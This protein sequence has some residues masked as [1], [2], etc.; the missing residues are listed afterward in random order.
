MTTDNSDPTPDSST[1][2]ARAGWSPEFTTRT[3]SPPVYLTTAFDIES[4]EQ[5]DA[6]TSGQEKGYIYTRDGNPNHEAFANDV[7]R[8]EGAEA[9]VVTASGMGALTAVLMAMT[10][11]GEQVIA[12]RV[13][14]GRTGQL[15]NHLAS[16][17]GLKVSYFDIDNLDELRT[18]VTPQT[19]LCIVESISN[20]LLEVADIPAIVE[21]LNGVPLL[22]DSTFATPCLLRPID[23]GAMLV[24]HSASK[25]LNGHGDVMA[26]VVVGPKSLIRKIRAMSSLYGVNANPFESWLAARGLRT[27][28]LR[29]SRVSQSAM[30]I[31]QFLGTKPQIV[32]VCYPG[33]DSHPHFVRAQKFLPNGCG[34][35]LAFDLA[36]GRG[37]VDILFRA[38][39]DVIPFSPTL[40]D[41]RTTLSY[42]AG[43]SHKFMT[44]AERAA[45][46]IGDGLV[47]LSIGL[48]DPLDLQR[49]LG[50]A[51]ALIG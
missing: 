32:R 45:C 35:M 42:P 24:W 6:V 5:L 43:T 10:K 30:N 18:A 9:G 50:N 2:A 46:G 11:T 12:A 47:R 33:L 40:A 26:G 21:I 48:E 29:M 36:G 16:S 44:A 34:G 19:R 38:L 4:L 23:H 28:P 13:L 25:Y 41:S 37:A 3:S 49:E 7:A 15:L 31:A 51:I 27:L 1:V 22:V 39:A 20:P 8:L 14:Y 17:F